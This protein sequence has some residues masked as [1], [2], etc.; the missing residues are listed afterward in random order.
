MVAKLSAFLFLNNVSLYSPGWP[1][2]HEPLPQSPECW[3]FRCVPLTAV[4]HNYLNKHLINQANN[5]KVNY[6]AH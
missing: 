2:T 1:W 4:S 6:F 5:N 3:D